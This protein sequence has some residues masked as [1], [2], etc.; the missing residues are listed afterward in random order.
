[1]A[2]MHSSAFLIA[3]SFRSS[4]MKLIRPKKEEDYDQGLYALIRSN[5]L[6]H[7]SVCC[8]KVRIYVLWSASRLHF[9]SIRYHSFPSHSFPA[10]LRR[11]MFLS[12]LVF[13][14]FFH[15]LTTV[16]SIN[17]QVLVGANNT[18]TFSPNTV[19]AVPGDTVEFIFAALVSIICS[20]PTYCLRNTEHES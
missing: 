19:R 1:M 6:L 9:P 11:K 4:N 20:T 8:S 10:N 12:K 3:I 5:S 7:P 17:I 18:I 2:R 13:V 16:H 15:L 14:W